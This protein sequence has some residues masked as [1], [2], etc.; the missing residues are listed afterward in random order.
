MW[1]LNNKIC[2]FL[3][4]MM[5][6]KH[7]WFKK[8]KSRIRSL[9]VSYSCYKVVIFILFLLLSVSIKLRKRWGDYH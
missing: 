6:F 1:I 7:H 5:L 2:G 3:A 8:L 4:F 9:S